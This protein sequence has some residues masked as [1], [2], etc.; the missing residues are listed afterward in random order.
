MKYKDMPPPIIV[1]GCARSGT[2]L[3]AGIINICGAYGG[4]LAPPNVNN[5]KG[6]FENTTVRQTIVK[7]YLREHGWDPLGQNPLPSIPL[8]KTHLTPK[9]IQE[10]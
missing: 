4:T 6:M 8:V 3:T 5:R 1:T 9:F 2:S 7:P 10:W